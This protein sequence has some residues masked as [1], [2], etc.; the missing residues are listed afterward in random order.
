MWRRPLSHRVLKLVKSEL[1]H[2]AGRLQRQPTQL[3]GLNLC[4]QPTQLTRSTKFYQ[5]HSTKQYPPTKIHHYP[6]S[7]LPQ[8]S[9]KPQHQVQKHSVDSFYPPAYNL[10][11]GERRKLMNIYEAL[12]FYANFRVQHQS[13]RILKIPELKK[14]KYLNLNH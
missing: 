5:T 14:S 4:V 13:S 8:S 10:N 3:V 12:S 1:M 7:K 6:H 2:P 11:H 9:T